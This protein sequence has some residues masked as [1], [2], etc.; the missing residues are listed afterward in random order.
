MLTISAKGVYGLTA[1]IELAYRFNS[2]PTQIKEISAQYSIPQ[3]YLEQILVILK[4]SGLVISYRG[5]QGGYALAVPPEKI[6]VIDILGHLEGNLKIANQGRAESGLEFLWKEI[7]NRIYA[8]L[9]IDLKK[10][11]EMK[12]N[13]KNSIMYYI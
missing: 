11:L 8:F 13:N 7:E 12:S 1:M 4:R 3:H 9:E 10:L 2:G 5:A 6:K